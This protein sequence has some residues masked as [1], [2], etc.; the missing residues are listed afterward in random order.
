V[1]RLPWKD[2]AFD[3]GVPVLEV[4]PLPPVSPVT[5]NQWNPWNM[6]DEQI[7]VTFKKPC[8]FYEPKACSLR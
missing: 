8:L 3:L 6:T 1:R 4:A 7:L 5:V 2:E